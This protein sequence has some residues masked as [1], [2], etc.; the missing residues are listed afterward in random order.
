MYSLW[1]TRFP[2]IAKTKLKRRPCKINSTDALKRC[3]AHQQNTADAL[4]GRTLRGLHM[5]ERFR[6]VDQQEVLLLSEC[7][8]DQTPQHPA[9]SVYNNHLSQRNQWINKKCSKCINVC[10][11]KTEMWKSAN[12]MI[13]LDSYDANLCYAL[14]MKWLAYWTSVSN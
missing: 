12:D 3:S 1:K 6:L 11:M 5:S 13:Y 8:D 7:T 10:N 14:P 9:H 4:V 2:L